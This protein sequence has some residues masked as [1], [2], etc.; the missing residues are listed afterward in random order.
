M[1]LVAVTVFESRRGKLDSEYEVALQSKT[2]LFFLRRQ[3]DLARRARFETLHSI[4]RA[5]AVTGGD[6]Q[7]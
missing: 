2:D 6:E 1:V 3:L 4:S 5:S 7:K